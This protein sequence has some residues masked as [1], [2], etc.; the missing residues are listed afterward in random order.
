MKL[1]QSIQDKIV[2]FDQ[3][4]KGAISEKVGLRLIREKKRWLCLNDLF[5]LCCLTG[6]GKIRDWENFYKPF[7]DEVS[8]IN[9][10][11]AELGIHAP[12]E[13][14]LPAEEAVDQFLY[15]Q[16]LYLCYR[17]FYKTTIVTKVNTLQLLLNFPN[18]HICLAHNKQEN[19]SD[20]LVTIKNYFLSTSIKQIFP[21]CVPDSK[22]WGNMS[23]FS[24]NN[25]TDWNVDEQNLEAVGVDTEITGRHWQVAKKDDLVTEKSVNTA[26]QILKT[27]KWDET[28]NIGHFHDAKFPVQDYSGTRYHFA[29]MYSVKKNDPKIKLVEIP[30]M[31]S[32]TGEI[33]HPERYGIEDINDLKKDMWVFNCQMMLK[34]EDPAKMTFK[35]EMIQTY[36]GIPED[37]NFYLIVDPASKRKKKSD[38]TAMLVVGINS[39]G[40]RYIVDGIRDKLNPAQRIDAAVELA[41]RWNIKESGWEEVGLGDD[42][43]Y[44]EER[45]RKEHL[46]FTVTPVK[47]M[48]VAKED[49]IRNILVPEY[50]SHKW[51][52]PARGKLVK[53]SLFHGRNFDLME[54]L[55]EEF[56][57][58]PLAQH[59]DLMDCQTFLNQLSIVKPVRNEKVIKSGLTLGEY[60]R[61]REEKNQYQKD[62]PWERFKVLSRV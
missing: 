45:R 38:Y 10:K 48:Q 1:R 31:N 56:M 24:L 57:Q 2:R 54:L 29:D 21:E 32:D 62:H 9:W 28:F 14:M 5:Y 52:W 51:F 25:R 6:N 17:M 33:T 30:I 36:E 34:P 46:F 22:D 18:L 37:L 41:R 55:E 7:C 61:I 58:F 19:A 53:Y 4:I 26:E 23:G 49:R 42:N 20:L 3:A 27:M 40:H 60:V 44:L 50:A 47:T 16:R 39:E 11:I 12:S 13:E 43:F 8:M 35:K 59:D 15:I